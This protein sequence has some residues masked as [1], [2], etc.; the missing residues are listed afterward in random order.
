MSDFLGELE[1]YPDL[2]GSII[3]TT[4]IHKVL[5]AMIKLHS[6]PLD[7]EFQFKKRSHDLLDKW[8]TTLSNDAAAGGSGDKEEDGKP[9]AADAK[10]NGITKKN[11][12]Q[13]E[14]AE[15]G[16]AAA[17]EEAKDED[18]EKKIGTTV[19]GEKEADEEKEP[20]ADKTAEEKKTDGPAVDSAPTEEYKPPAETAEVTA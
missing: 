18:M 8:T 4:K 19:E 3:R 11:E 9:E 20:E 7:G 13:V 14:K 2:E 17:P 15:V 12:G 10:T 5:K 1:G 6:I 16:E